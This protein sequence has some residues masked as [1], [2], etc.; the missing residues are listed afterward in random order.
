MTCPK[1]DLDDRT[2]GT[3]SV[4][5]TFQG[6]QAFGEF[7]IGWTHFSGLYDFFHFESVNARKNITRNV[8]FEDPRIQFTV[9]FN[10]RYGTGGND[11][12]RTRRKW[13]YQINEYHFIVKSTYESQ[14][15]GY[16][17]ICFIAYCVSHFSL[18]LLDVAAARLENKVLMI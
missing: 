1:L 18:W 15:M 14:L 16:M 8:W 2:S 10:G 17:D 6:Q 13:I 7:I 5:I 11:E 12:E 4:W 3:R 9:W